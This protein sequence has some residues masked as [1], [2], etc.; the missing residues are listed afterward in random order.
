MEHL[1]GSLLLQ[2]TNFCR[3]LKITF[4]WEKDKL[5]E[6]LPGGL[7]QGSGEIDARYFDACSRQIPNPPH[8]LM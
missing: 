5:L 8:H 2:T 3:I 7:T 1:Y 6:L 4:D